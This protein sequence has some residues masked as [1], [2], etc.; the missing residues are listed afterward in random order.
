[1]CEQVAQ[2]LAGALT[3][4]EEDVLRD[5]LVVE[6]LPAPD[7]SHL[8][9]TLALAPSAPARAPAEVLEHLQRHEPRLRGEVAAAIRRRRTP[10]LTYRL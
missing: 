1:L 8:M 4:S 10:Q 2:T 7:A 6:V 9:V 5:L 3:E